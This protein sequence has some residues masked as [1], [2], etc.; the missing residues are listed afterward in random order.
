MKYK[1]NEETRIA[2][3]IQILFP[4]TENDFTIGFCKQFKHG[5]ALEPCVRLYTPYRKQA[6]HRY[7]CDEKI[8][9]YLYK[10]ILE[11]CGLP[12]TMN[13]SFL[14]YATS[15][16]IQEKKIKFI[17]DE[18]TLNLFSTKIIKNY[19]KLICKL[20]E[21]GIHTILI[22]TNYLLIK[23]IAELTKDLDLFYVRFN[24]TIDLNFAEY[25][26]MELE[27]GLKEWI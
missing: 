22:T 21:H 5:N 8:D 7:F 12:E 10:T 3:K 13:Y 6:I 17:L 27:N 19:A 26:L 15:G 14:I 2:D 1:L 18:R 25:G 4:D 9:H 11:E 20:N 24:E 16:Y 23:Y